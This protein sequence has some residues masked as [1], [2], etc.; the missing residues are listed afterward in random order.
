MDTAHVKPLLSHTH[1]VSRGA[2]GL[3]GQTTCENH[4]RECLTPDSSAGSVSED[5]APSAKTQTNQPGA[6]GAH[7]L[8]SGVWGFASKPLLQSVRYGTI[9]NKPLL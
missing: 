1:T 8:L 4:L 6:G 9:R 2:G 3:P 7:P 5:R